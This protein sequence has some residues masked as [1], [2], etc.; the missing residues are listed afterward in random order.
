MPTTDDPHSGRR[1]EVTA[2]AGADSSPSQILAGVAEVLAT[3]DPTMWR[4]LLA[5]HL[6]DD[7]GR[8]TSCHISGVG[9][10]YWP[11]TLRAVAERA[12]ELATVAARPGGPARSRARMAASP[13]ERVGP[14][15]MT[16][17]LRPPPVPPSTPSR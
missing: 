17:P 6:A 13:V 2:R 4:R 11:C 9:S 12:Q 5:D 15:V 14:A 3:G 7:Q 16:E 10:P 8:C 1:S